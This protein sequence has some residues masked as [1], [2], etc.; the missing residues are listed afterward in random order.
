MIGSFS[1]FA[2]PSLAASVIYQVINLKG[3]RTDL[4]ALHQS[5]IQGRWAGREEARVAVHID[6]QRRRRE[7][8]LPWINRVRSAAGTGEKDAIAS[9]RWRRTAGSEC[10]KYHIFEGKQIQTLL[11]SVFSLLVQLFNTTAVIDAAA[12]RPARHNGAKNL[13]HLGNTT[14]EV[15]Q[16]MP[17]SDNH[18]ILAISSCSEN[19]LRSC[20][21]EQC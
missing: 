5:G 15:G 2:E 6:S 16:I 20:E 8:C 3:P 1:F 10:R 9:C 13:S 14:K 12:T 11:I 19:R 4:S 7:Y 17:I 21:S 18:R